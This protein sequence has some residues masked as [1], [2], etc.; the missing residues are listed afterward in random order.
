MVGGRSVHIRSLTSA[1]E[2]AASDNYAYLNT[3]V[4]DLPDLLHNLRDNFVIQS[5]SVFARKSLAA[6]FNNYSR[7]FIIHNSPV[8]YQKKGTLRR[9]S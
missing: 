3:A 4:A 5:E 1:P 2:I 8:F 7:V 6:D 9:P